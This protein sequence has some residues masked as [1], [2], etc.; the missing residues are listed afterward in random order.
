MIYI[1]V[2]PPWGHYDEPTHFEYAWMIANRTPFPKAG[3]Y[4]APL[5][6]Q[7]L[8]SMVS[9]DFYELRG[10]NADLSNLKDPVNIGVNQLGDPPVYYFLASIPLRFMRGESVEN[11]MLAGRFVS[12]LLFLIAVLVSWKFSHEIASQGNSVRWMIPLSLVLLPSLVE[13][14]TAVSNDSAAVLVYSLFL[15]FGVRLIKNGP[16]LTTILT[17][18]LLVVIG[19]FTKSS[20]WMMGI[21]FVIALIVSFFRNKK[22]LVGWGAIMVAVFTALLALFEWGDAALWYRATIQNEPTRVQAQIDG[23]PLYALQLV[24]ESSEH[25][26]ILYQTLLN[27]DLQKISGAQVTIGAWMWADQ[28]MEAYPPQFMFVN[29]KGQK[30]VHTAPV[31][32]RQQP[33]FYAYKVRLP[34]NLSRAYIAIKP[35]GGNEHVGKIYYANPVLAEGVYARR[36]P[37]EFTDDSTVHGTWAGKSF[38][39]LVRNAGTIQSW[40]KFRD[41]VYTI[42][43]KIDY[44]LA[45]GIGH[46]LYTLDFKGTAWYS[47]ET[48]SVIFRSF[49]AKF[50]WG[51]ITLMGAKPYRTFLIAMAFMAAGCLLGIKN[52]ISWPGIQVALWLGVNIFFSLGYAWF[53]GISMNS[54]IDKS[55]IPVAR[56]IF[57]SI[58]AILAV[59]NFGWAFWIEIIRVRYRWIGYVLFIGLFLTLDVMAI[60]TVYQYYWG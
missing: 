16:K 20:T 46:V 58:L 11:Q 5:R 14:M 31:M 59:F 38:T 25:T 36:I 34:V 37:P 6:R 57:P 7:I 1:F 55:Y 39:N 51:E 45:E 53:T 4:D 3:D 54:F 28:P 2:V 47:K 26:P 21:A 42:A 27:A 33:T 9:H 48:L 29:A 60:I 50:G 41:Y 15:W 35:F 12:L 52:K 56:F 43:D 17:L 18:G 23:S 19:F 30:W 44:R 24:D 49:W 13:L 8:G 10:W 40:P 22:T 32:L